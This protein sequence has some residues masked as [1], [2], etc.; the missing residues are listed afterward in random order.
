[1]WRGRYADGLCQTLGV[2]PVVSNVSSPCVPLQRAAYGSNTNTNTNTKYTCQGPWCAAGAA[3]GHQPGPEPHHVCARPGGA[4]DSGMGTSCGI[5]RH[6]SLKRTRRFTTEHSV[7]LPRVTNCA[8][9]CATNRAAARTRARRP[10]AARAR[11]T[12]P[13]PR[14]RRARPQRGPGPSDTSRGCE[15]RMHRKYKYKYMVQIYLR[16]HVWHTVVARSCS[17]CRARYAARS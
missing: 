10:R 5:Q 2:P 12:K 8:A 17:Q 9:V 4:R 7:Q 6:P 15:R 1:M 13:R 14:A 11:T 16:P 3:S